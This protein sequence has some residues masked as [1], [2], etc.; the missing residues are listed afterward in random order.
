MHPIN[1]VSLQIY[2]IKDEFHPE[3]QLIV[4]LIVVIL[5]FN[6]FVFQFREV[7]FYYKEFCESGVELSCN[8]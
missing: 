7:V 8:W 6:Q 5:H 3:I 1:D 4:C 2:R